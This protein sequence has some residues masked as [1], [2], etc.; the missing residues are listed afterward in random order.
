MLLKTLIVIMAVC[1][2]RVA[3]QFIKMAFFGLTYMGYQ[4][5]LKE[6]SVASQQDPIR[7]KTQLGFLALPPLKNQNPPPRSIIPID[8]ASQY[9]Q[10]PDDSYTEYIRL[11][12][13]HTRNP[14]GNCFI[15][16]IYH[17]VFSK[18]LNNLHVI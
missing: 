10:G 9:G 16:V 4:N 17:F 11:R 14:C 12:T 7:S 3:E 6:V 8:Q 2:F 15:F 13:K 18:F 1:C 5:T